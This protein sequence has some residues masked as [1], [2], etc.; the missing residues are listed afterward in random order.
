MKDAE[1]S[2]GTTLDELEDWLTEEQADGLMHIWTYTDYFY[3]TP[4]PTSSDK[5]Y[6]FC[7]TFWQKVQIQIR[8]L[9]LIC[10]YTVCWDRLSKY[11]DSL[12][13]DIKEKNYISILLPIV[14][15]CIGNITI[16][17]V[18]KMFSK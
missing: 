14:S 9:S 11:L 4:P 10:V 18:H 12:C 7:L 3:S 17:V 13:I 5:K 8:L 2:A 6:P 15:L 16:Y 1:G